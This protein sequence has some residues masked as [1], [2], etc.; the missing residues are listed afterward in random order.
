MADDD[1]VEGLLHV[2]H[3]GVEVPFTAGVNRLE[4]DGARLMTEHG[5]PQGIGK[6]SG[7]VDG[8]DCNAVSVE[9]QL[10]GQCGRGGGF[11]DSTRATADEDALT[12]GAPQVRKRVAQGRFGSDLD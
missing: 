1:A 10:Q 2:E 9:G 4:I 8:D 6:T 12:H 7:R 5:K 11:T 3:H